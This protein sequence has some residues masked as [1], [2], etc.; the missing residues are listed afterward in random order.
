MKSARTQLG[1]TLIEL[2]VVIAIIALLIGILLP[3]LGAA[4]QLA[5]QTK[6]LANERSVVQGV[7]AYA[8]S[9]K[10]LYPPHY[11]YGRDE[12]GLDWRFEDQQQT[13]PNPANGYVHWSYALFSSGSVNE[14]SF[15]SGGMPSGGAP[16]ANPG[17]N[18]KDWESGQVNDLGGTEGA[19]TPNDR[20]VK[21]VGYVGN[22]A[23]FPRNKFFS[24]SGERKN[25]LVT[26][27]MIFNPSKVIL[28]AEVNPDRGY[29]ALKVDGVIK[30]HRPVTPFIGASSGEDVYGEVDGPSPAGRFRY[31]NDS[32]ILPLADIPE[33]AINYTSGSTLNAIGRIWGKSRGSGDG[34]TTNFGFVDGHCENLKLRDTLKNRLWGDRFWSITGDDRVVPAAR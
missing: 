23:I 1:F 30:S 14:E 6:S 29:A 24:S 16:A 34:G 26:D 3:S 12:Q 11:V 17:E 18:V 10:Q 31:A 25:E 19:S 22:G 27:A 20:Q 15:Q 5:R 8:A 32:E 28:V 33:G 9:G 4:R 2:L 7:A 13:N 21:R